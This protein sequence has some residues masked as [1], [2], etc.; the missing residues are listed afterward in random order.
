MKA[1]LG[2]AAAIFLAASAHAAPITVDDFNTLQTST[3]NTAN[4]VAVSTVAA[5]TI[6][7][8][9]FTRTLTVNQTEH[10]SVDP[11][12]ASTAD[13]GFGSLKL[14]NDSETN[15]LISATYNI[16]SLLDDVAGGSELMLS[17]L[18]T[19]A[20]EGQ[21]FTIAGF[22]NDALIGSQTFTGPGALSFNL[23]GLATSG[24]TLRLLFSGG[25][26][27]DSELGPISLQI[28]GGGIPV[29][30]PGAL[31]LLVLG[32]VGIAIGRRRKRTA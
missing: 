8:N 31:G 29:P 19:D 4:G 6:D 15:S 26:A 11:R 17:V 20:S 9:A 12:L 3:D 10:S 32:L 18:F 5:Y 16:D 22:L 30:E 1:L 14:S 13:A 27:F 28:N 7:G 2:T 24:N 21:A 25:T 23:P